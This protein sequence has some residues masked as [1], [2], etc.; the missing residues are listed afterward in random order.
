MLPLA[1]SQEFPVLYSALFQSYTADKSSDGAQP[2]SSLASPQPDATSRKVQNLNIFKDSAYQKLFQDLETLDRVNIR[3][4]EK[5]AVSNG[6]LL[7]QKNQI[8]QTLVRSLWNTAGYGY[9]R[10]DISKH[11]NLI[12]AL[13]IKVFA[14]MLLDPEFA[15][16]GAEAAHFDTLIK[17]AA[18]KVELVKSHYA[19]RTTKIDESILEI[20]TLSED[21]KTLANHP[22]NA[23]ANELLNPKGAMT[24]ERIEAFSAMAGD[25]ETLD[26]SGVE[27]ALPR[28]NASTMT[29]DDF[30]EIIGM[31]LKHTKCHTILIP[32]EGNAVRGIP[33]LLTHQ[34]F[35]AEPIFSTETDVPKDFRKRMGLTYTRETNIQ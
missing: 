20:N 32:Q 12:H 22:F 23:I 1:N 15:Q 24:K 18:Q 8:G 7:I 35:K 19:G 9:N 28:A 2:E 17:N 11:L 26:L 29:I 3:D 5:L 34:G 14:E 4:G 31:V 6:S 27:I 16:H 21:F 13:A 33:E 30:K 25:V 10:N